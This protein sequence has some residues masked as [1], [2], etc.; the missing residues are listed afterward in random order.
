VK[1]LGDIGQ[2]IQQFPD[3]KEGIKLSAFS[4]L[5]LPFTFEDD[6][7]EISIESIYINEKLGLLELS[8]KVDGE[9]PNKD[10]IFQFINPPI[11]VHDG[12]FTTVEKTRTIYTTEGK[13]EESYTVEEPNFIE[14]LEES[15]KKMIVSAIGGK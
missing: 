2:V 7:R 4:Q 13:K 14:D 3:E 8:V 15:L 6:G 5:I 10:G 9:K 1:T 11:M 12:T